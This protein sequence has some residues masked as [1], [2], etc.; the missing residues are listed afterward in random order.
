MKIQKPVIFVKNNLKTNMRKM[1]NIVKLE[2]N[3]Y[4]EKYR[5]AAHS[6]FNLK[7]DVSKK[8]HIAFHNDLT[9]IIILS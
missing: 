2:G 1:K 4:T 7:Y 6:I 3:I 8:I 5:G 9:M